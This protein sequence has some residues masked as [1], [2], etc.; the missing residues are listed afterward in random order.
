MDADIVGIGFGPA[1]IAL[2]IAL[3]E[4]GAGTQAV[5]IEQLA[6]P[7]WQSGM[8]LDGSDIQ[9]NAVRDLVMPRNPRSRFTFHNYLFEQGRLFEYL[10]LGLPFPLRKDY[11]KYI[12]W[13]A[14]QFRDQ[15]RY[16]S[17]VTSVDKLDRGDGKAGA[18]VH[19]S[20]GQSISCRAVVVAPG[21]APRIP[22]AFAG[23][24]DRRVYHFTQYLHRVADLER[25]AHPRIAVIGGSQSAVELTLDLSARLPDASVHNIMRGF[26]YRQKDL[27]PFTGEVYFPSFIDYYYGCSDAS[28]RDLNQ[29]LRYTNYSAADIDVI[30]ALYVRMYEQ[31]LDGVERIKV[32]RNT[33]VTACLPRSED[34]LL[35]LREV[36]L[37]EPA[38][39][40]FDAVILATGFQDLTPYGEGQFLPGVLDPLVGDVARTPAGFAMVGRDY[41]VLPGDGRT[42]PPVYLNGLCESSHGMGDAGSFSLLSQRSDTIATSVIQAMAPVSP[43]TPVAALGSVAP[44]AAV[45]G[46]GR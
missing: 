19:L 1:N 14:D 21:R 33:A 16:A 13:A 31:R 17:T 8:M 30:Q 15:V 25:I 38:E 46:S 40:P 41:R 9:H 28:Q 5:Y 18:R 35:R 43:A 2:A 11:V 44:V 29:Q 20:D 3:Q 6:Q 27:S 45:S 4:S 42:L 22:A 32:V 12:V 39:L 10:N 7:S 26:G 24:T 34:V 36:H 37:D 23:I